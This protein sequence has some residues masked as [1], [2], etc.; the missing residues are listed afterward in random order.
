MQLCYKCFDPVDKAYGRKRAPRF[1]LECS[2]AA[3]TVVCGDNGN[4]HF[5]LPYS[6]VEEK[7]IFR[8]LPWLAVSFTKLLTCL[9]QMCCAL[10]KKS[11]GKF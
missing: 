8:Q 1:C 11:A 6:A 2:L 10:L 4:H 7:D 9:L 3:V 5:F